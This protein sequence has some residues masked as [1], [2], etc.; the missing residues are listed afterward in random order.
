MILLL[1]AFENTTVL[2]HETTHVPGAGS[3]E[4]TLFQGAQAPTGWPEDPGNGRWLVLNSRHGTWVVPG[5]GAQDLARHEPGLELFTEG[6]TGFGAKRRLGFVDGDLVIVNEA[7]TDRYSATQLDWELRHGRWE[8]RLGGEQWEGALLM[9]RPWAYSPVQ[10]PTWT[11]RGDCDGDEDASLQVAAHARPEALDLRLRVFDD[12]ETAPSDASDEALVD[13]DHIEVWL[14]GDRQLGVSLEDQPTA[15]WLKGSGEV[16]EV[17]W[18]IDVLVIELPWASLGE[19][20]H[21]GGELVGSSTEWT[22]PVG[23]SWPMTV[24]FSDADGSGQQTRLA[25]STLEGTGQ[26]LGRLFVLDGAERFPRPPGA[27]RR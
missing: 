10:V 5:Y 21:Q 20:V 11:V 9:A 23:A 22:H 14:D 2:H 6:M 27:E 8:D 15:R 16:P 19:G 13:A 4:F 25:T 3:V 24:V 26:K 18:D 7:W 1:L 17:R 12:E